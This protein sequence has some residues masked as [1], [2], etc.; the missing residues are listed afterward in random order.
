[1]TTLYLCGAG[2]SEGVRIAHTINRQERRWRRIVLLDDDP[3]KHG[4]TIL[5]VE[6]VGPIDALLEADPDSSEV[7]NLVARSTVTRWTVRQRIASCRIPFAPLIDPGVYTGGVSFGKDLIVYQHAT[8]GPEVSIGEGGVV[9]MGAVVGHESE[10]GECCVIAANAVVN[11]RVSLGDGVYV[12]SNATIL[13]EVSVGAGAT[14]GAGS[15]VIEDVPDGATVMGVPAGIIVPPEA[16]YG[17]RE[18]RPSRIPANQRVGVMPD[19]PAGRNAG[20]PDVAQV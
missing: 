8:L 19:V 2:N 16:G 7:A 12:G 14:I 6:I 5:D 4:R 13:P 20:V 11:A 10:V 9:F 3:A 15:A 18:G 17:W 1:M